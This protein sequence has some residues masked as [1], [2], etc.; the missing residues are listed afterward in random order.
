MG[1]SHLSWERISI[2]HPVCGTTCLFMEATSGS[3]SWEHGWSLQWVPH[4][5][6]TGR[7]QKLDIIDYFLVSTPVRPLIQKCELVKS[8]PWGPHCGVKLVLNIN[9][10]SVVSRQLIGKISKR[11]RHNTN[12]LQGQ[13]T[14]HTEE[15]D[16]STVERSKTQLCFRRQE[17]AFQDG[18]EDT[19]AACKRVSA[20][21][22]LKEADELGHLE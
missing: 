22:F 21:G 17:A 9:F 3:K 13:S 14:H 15:A 16:P 8:V 19:Q 20:C 5:C 10:D 18:Q 11:S 6:R 12:A 1:N 4:T 7:G 2:S